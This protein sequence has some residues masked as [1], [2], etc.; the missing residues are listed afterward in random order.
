MKNLYSHFQNKVVITFLL[1]LWFIGAIASQFLSPGLSIMLVVCGILFLA[2]LVSAYNKMNYADD[3]LLKKI[4]DMTQNMYKG[5]LNDR[6]T[7]I[8][9]EHELARLAWCLNGICD[10]METYFH[11]ARRGFE[12]IEQEFYQRKPQPEGLSGYYA[13][14]L[15]KISETFQA[16]EKNQ[17]VKN[18][19][20]FFSLLN[21]RKTDNLLTSLNLAQTDLIE[22]TDNMNKMQQKT[23]ES[24]ESASTV[25]S[26]LETIT[27]DV[28]HLQEII[29]EVHS[30]S[31]TIAENTGKI[32]EILSL[33]VGIADQTNLLALNAAIEAARA[34][35]QGR[36]FAVVA[37]E[38]RS[39]SEKTKE[40]TSSVSSV[41]N[42][43]N[44]DSKELTE[45][46][47]SMKQMAQDSQHA[48]EN[49]KQAVNVYSENTLHT[50]SVSSYTQSI[51]SS[52]LAKVDHLI[53]LQ[54][55]YKALESGPESEAYNKCN[56]DYNDCDFTN[57]FEA[58]EGAQNYSHLPAYKA[59]EAPHH[60]A[61]ES[62]RQAMKKVSGDWEGNVKV[63]NEILAYFGVAE[64][65]CL[66]LINSITKMTKEKN[67]YESVSTDNTKGESE[68][69]LF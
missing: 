10:Q 3:P 44:H 1:L 4:Q 23:A 18:K 8:D 60:S 58:G 57:W 38:V 52:S 65:A 54:Y 5:E 13:N 21:E 46:A 50:H 51:S 30:Y 68:V 64:H 16:Y 49:F 7:H 2:T 40:A 43:F 63:Q 39:L 42:D 27:R 69:E 32:S 17:K 29:Q 62:I 24:V 31:L 56:I 9:S 19:D 59:I 26:S 47:S 12:S 36:G 35:E 22:I 6:I 37:D 33:I 20:A 11:E 14:T 45:K 34:G 67:Q 61:H 41:I 55:A 53:F 15:N 48:I 25:G 28:T 66:E